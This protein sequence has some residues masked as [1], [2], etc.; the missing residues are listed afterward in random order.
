MAYVPNPDYDETKEFVPRED[1]SEWSP[2]GMLGVLTVRDDG[3]CKVNS[4]AK[5]ADGGIATHST[6]K[7][8][9]RVIKRVND[10]LVK[11]VFR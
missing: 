6:D 4:Y 11:V 10:H 2:I 9:Y 5:V 1:R 8:D 3:T 7:N